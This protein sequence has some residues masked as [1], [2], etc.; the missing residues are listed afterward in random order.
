MAGA[1]SFARFVLGL[2]LVVTVAAL[3]GGVAA[4]DTAT[5]NPGPM[6]VTETVSLCVFGGGLLLAAVLA[7]FGFVLM[8]LC[9]IA[10]SL[11]Q[12]ATGGSWPPA[13]RP[14]RTWTR[15]SGSRRR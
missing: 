7:W 2:A 4:V 6:T 1:R 9:D 11:A 14:A 3:G 8:V 15:R 12:G 13:P 10:G 5:R